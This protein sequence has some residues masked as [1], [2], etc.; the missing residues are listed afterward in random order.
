MSSVASCPNMQK[1]SVDL[2]T[3]QKSTQISEYHCGPAVL[4]MLLSNIGISVSQETI[5]KAA[6]ISKTI[7]T[8]GTRIDHMCLALERLHLDAVL[9]YKS[10]STIEDIR[11]ILET[12]HYPVGVEWQGLFTDDEDAVGDDTGHYSVVARVDFLRKSLII[13]DPYKDFAQQDRI[14]SNTTFL[15]R[16]WDE[17]EVKHPVT[18]KKHIVRDERVLFFVTPGTRNFPETLGL[19]PGTSYNT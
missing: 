2:V 14:I 1:P 19:L 18:H 11:H 16:W 10:G 4:Q 13:V 12:Y 17:N 3:F 8:H 7:E 15:K 6:G 5:T 9:W